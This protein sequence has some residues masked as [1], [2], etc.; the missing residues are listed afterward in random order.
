MKDC[1]VLPA[2]RYLAT[3]LGLLVGLGL[4]GCADAGPGPESGPPAQLRVV[5]GG[6]QTGT[7]ALAL[8]EPVVA[9]VT[10]AEDRPV[11]GVLVSFVASQGSGGFAPESRVTDGDGKAQAVWTLGTRSGAQNGSVASEGVPS[12]PLSAIA[13]AGAPARLAFESSPEGAIVGVDFSPPVVVQVQDDFG[14][15][16]PTSSA[17]VQLHLN[18]GALVGGGSAPAIEGRATFGGLRIDQSGTGY[19]LTASTEGLPAATSAA[20]PVVTAAAATLQIAAG[21]AQAA[22]AGAAVAVPPAVVVRD[23][24]GNGIAGVEVTFAVTGGG[25]SVAPEITTTGIDGRAAPELWTL[26]TAVGRNTL[27]ASA[28]ALPGASVEFTAEAR[29][30]PVSPSRSTVT[31][32]PSSVLT[33]ETSTIEVTAMDAFGNAVPGASVQLSA[34]GAGNTLVQPPV[35]DADGRA[36]G[37]LGSTSA[38]SK[39]VSADA[40]GVTLE[41]QATVVVESAPTVTSVEVSPGQAAL[42]VDQT[43]ALTATV[44]DQ[45]DQP[46]DGVPV[47][48]SS[49]DPAVA[50]VAADG[51][52]TAHDVGSATITATAAGES[53]SAQISVS[54]GEGARTDL[55]YCTIDGVADKMDVYVPSASKPRP[56]PVAVHVHG[57]GWVSGSRST[58]TRFAEMKQV[59]LDRGYLVVSLDYRLAPAYKYPAQI[60]DV[61]CA[62]RHLRGRAARY[63]LDPDRIGVWGGSAGGQLVALLGTAGPAVGFDDV[64]GF[65]GES[66][67]V[68]AVIALSAITDFTHPDE[69]R[70]DYGRVF[71]T[72]PDADSPEMIE[73]SPVTHVTADDAPF[74]FIVGDEDDLVLPAQSV[75][76][77]QLLLDAGVTSSLLRVLHADHDFQPV[78]GPIDPTSQEITARMAAFFDQ[79]LR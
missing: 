66:S 77:N 19:V 71:R 61:K 56:L 34:T 41:Q 32:T 31:A 2:D 72:W 18:K 35:T 12:A 33:G 7:V 59:L 24:G 37:S 9:R 73:A 11:P 54:F 76:M 70:D 36:S 28:A 26:G 51:V 13:A 48:W 23:G 65:Q 30:G 63:G 55:T 68:Q 39:T 64:G 21:D 74:F 10:D 17:D 6:G 27:R 60:Q 58:G 25:G 75:R 79:H 29:P 3:G 50:S 14:N 1:S 4:W 67:E 15:V 38:G 57:G 44:L 5:G 52:V 22:A 40:G 47:S 62:I 69:L 46:M 53:G 20:F 16:A 45:E 49:S 8:G 78:S 43:T 42:V